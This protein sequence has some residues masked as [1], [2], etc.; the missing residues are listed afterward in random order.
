MGI[1][2]SRAGSPCDRRGADEISQ[3]LQSDG[4]GHAREIFLVPH[5]GVR[6]SRVADWTDLSRDCSA[7]AHAVCDARIAMDEATCLFPCGDH[8][9]E[10]AGAH[11]G[12][13][14]WKD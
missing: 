7:S 14:V 6:I 4:L 11:D 1:S 13:S 2:L 8:D 12:D 9:S 5:A 3:C 10:W